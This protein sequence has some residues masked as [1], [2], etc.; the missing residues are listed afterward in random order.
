M[1]GNR[2]LEEEVARLKHTIHCLEDCIY[3]MDHRITALY[4]YF[5]L[6]FVPGKQ[7]YHPASAK[8]RERPVERPNPDEFPDDRPK[9]GRPLGSKN[10][11]E[12]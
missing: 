7:E 3:E 1:F 6:E 9:G 12:D 2:H 4:E 8:K 10:R 5:D 11:R